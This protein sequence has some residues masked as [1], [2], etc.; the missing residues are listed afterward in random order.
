M[1]P[2]ICNN[3]F[4][5]GMNRMKNKRKFSKILT[6]LVLASIIMIS[7][8]SFAFAQE[9]EQNIEVK[10]INSIVAMI[11]G[12]YRF[13]ANEL[14]I[15]KDIVE[16]LLISHP[17]L[18]EEAIAA[19][20]NS[21]DKYSE[22]YSKED[23]QGF[24]QLIEREYVGIGVTVE[25]VT[26]GVHISAVSPGGPADIA[27]V[28]V[29]DIIAKVEGED[30][31]NFSISEI[32]NKIRGEEGT[33]VNITVKRDGEL[34]DL[35]IV[36]A[37]V[38][39]ES[40]AYDTINDE[41]GYIV[42]AQFNSSTPG[43]VKTALDFFDLKGIKKIIIDVRDNPGGEL[44]GVLGTL[45]HFVPRG[46]L[47]LTIDYK[48]EGYDLNLRSQADFSETDREVVVLVNENSASAAEVFAGGIMYNDMGVT[49]GERT[50][51]K[52][53]VQEFVGL[54]S[55]EG[56]NLGDM[57]LTVAEYSLPNG[58]SIHGVGLKPTY[59]VKNVFES[60]PQKNL[61]A[62]LYEK[63]YTVGDIGKGVL[64]VK[65][66]L[67]LLG[68]YVG[69]VNDVFDEE[70]AVAVKTFQEKN[71]LFPYGVADFTTQTTLGQV[72][73]DAE[74]EIDRQLDK[75]YELL[76]GKSLLEETEEEE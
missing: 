71:G 13:D 2:S 19:S 58:E 20:T 18:L 66:R 30:A 54:F 56:H 32:S 44:G 55:P 9:E 25:R 72:V 50:F 3:F 47:L 16:E 37:A 12:E 24:T 43:E 11:L 74:V 28:K 38:S 35:S 46:K 1:L 69:E 21:L 42:I 39:V 73:I 45:Y 6:S 23:V 26:G 67:D 76:T 8:M 10:Y 60:L 41:V 65:Q 64:A 27:G 52:G 36:R 57:K 49:V 61:S 75:A 40:S 29:G 53:S 5:K 14:E 48:K 34:I 33:T 22:Y 68:Y 7:Q 59:K 31:T 63:K 70:T 51:G 17:E 15:Y 62:L 4:G